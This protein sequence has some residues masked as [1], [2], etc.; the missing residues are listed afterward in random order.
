MKTDHARDRFEIIIRFVRFF[1]NLMAQLVVLVLYGGGG[2]G[3][4]CLDMCVMSCVVTLQW[5]FNDFLSG[6]VH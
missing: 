1:L 6:L 2:G 3:G 4:V 5:R